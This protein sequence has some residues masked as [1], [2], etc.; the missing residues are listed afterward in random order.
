MAVSMIFLLINASCIQQIAASA[1]LHSV[2]VDDYSGLYAEEVQLTIKEDSIEEYYGAFSF[3]VVV[4]VDFSAII[5]TLLLYRSYTNHEKLLDPE[6]EFLSAFVAPLADENDNLDDDETERL[7]LSLQY[8]DGKR[9][10]DPI[11]VKKITEA[12]YQLC[13]TKFGREVLR[14]KG[15][16]YIL[17]ELDK[18]TQATAAAANDS[19]SNRGDTARSTLINTD[20]TSMLHLLIG[21]L[22][23]YE[24]E[25]AVDPN[26]ESIRNLQ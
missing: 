11:I 16:Y 25:M 3:I 2:L 8:Y 17:R 10:S 22:I 19:V 18:A 20:E 26:L 21:I 15:I 24:S 14:K 6:D 13:A 4:V 23:R 9:C 7:P 5:V 1:H 12:L